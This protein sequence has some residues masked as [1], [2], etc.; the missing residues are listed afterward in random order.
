MIDYRTLSAASLSDTISS[1]GRSIR[2]A[3]DVLDGLL[4][5]AVWH[6][7]KDGQITPAVKLL[8]ESSRN[9]KGPVSQY[10]TKFG[11]LKYSK[12]KGLQFNKAKSASQFGIDAANAL[13]ETLPTLEE[14]FPSPAKQYKD[15]P[16][17]AGLKH[18][19]KKAQELEAHGHRLV[20]SSDEEKA[21]WESIQHL[22][23]IKG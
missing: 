3:D 12:E 4:A 22:V 17:I 20:A 19:V 9:M 5:V 11:N 8:A 10:L 2:L 15:M 18:L 21:L 23:A 7:V 13:F 14:A 16:L 1:Y 6:S